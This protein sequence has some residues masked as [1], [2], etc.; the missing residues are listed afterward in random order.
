MTRGQTK[1]AEDTTVIEEEEEPTHESIQKIH[2]GAAT[3]GVI[4]LGAVLT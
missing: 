1:E 4:M 3:N 2:A